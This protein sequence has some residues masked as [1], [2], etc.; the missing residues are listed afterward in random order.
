MTLNPSSAAQPLSVG[1]H[2]A[3]FGDGQ[4]VRKPNGDF[5]FI[6]GNAS[7]R[8]AAREWVSLS[9]SEDCQESR[10]LV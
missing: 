10:S 9:H 4:L 8:A 5:R 3:S 2:I 7:D 1:N 6:G